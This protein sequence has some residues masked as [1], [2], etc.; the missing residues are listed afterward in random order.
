MEL[1]H[2][3]TWHYWLVVSTHLKNISQ[4]G[5]FPQVGVKIK[6]IW[7]H[8]LDYK[9]AGNQGYFTPMSGVILGHYFPKK[10]FLGHEPRKPS[11][12]HNFL[13][14][15]KVVFGFLSH[16][17]HVWEYLPTYICLKFTVNVGKYSMHGAFGFG[18]SGEALN[19]K[20]FY[21]H[22]KTTKKSSRFAW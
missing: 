3:Y 7:N 11:S 6:N 22:P 21:D 16:T 17:L 5:S 4:V 1:F 19:L 18:P 2:P 20:I 13:V 8:H 14:R 15:P 9:W 12:K 10:R